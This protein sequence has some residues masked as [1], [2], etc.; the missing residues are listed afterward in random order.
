MPS[1]PSRRSKTLATGS[2]LAALLLS[3]L[4]LGAD[5]TAIDTA[6]GQI[7]QALTALKD[8]KVGNKQG[9]D[10]LE[11]ARGYLARARAELLKAQ[12][13]EGSE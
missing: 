4:A 12:G 1:S 9:D 7:S 3:S 13:Q 11:K 5:S 6:S 8:A 10:H 2:A